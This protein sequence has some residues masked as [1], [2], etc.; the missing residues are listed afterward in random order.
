MLDQGEPVAR[1]QHRGLSQGHRLVGARL[2]ADA[3]DPD[4]RFGTQAGSRVMAGLRVQSAGLGRG[5]RDEELTR[6]RHTVRHIPG[7]V[8]SSRPL[9]IA[10]AGCVPS[11]RSGLVLGRFCPGNVPCQRMVPLT[12]SPLCNGAVGQPQGAAEIH[13]IVV[14]G[15]SRERPPGCL[16]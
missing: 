1:L 11:F 2:A 12:K 7:E 8:V 15:E 5:A 6:N 4:P 10:P 13:V 3:D 14:L 9:M 16:R